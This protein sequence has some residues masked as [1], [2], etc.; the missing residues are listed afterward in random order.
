MLQARDIQAAVPMKM[1]G[2]WHGF[3]ILTRSTLMV[4]MTI[5][6]M[7]SGVVAEGM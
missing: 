1:R 5:T 2:P 6:L 3:R 7:I 4:K